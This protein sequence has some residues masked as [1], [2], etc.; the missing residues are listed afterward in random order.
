MGLTKEKVRRLQRD[1]LAHLDEISCCSM[2]M[3]DG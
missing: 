3:V 2:G 1:A